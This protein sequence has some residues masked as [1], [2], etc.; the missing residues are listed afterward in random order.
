MV[1][2]CDPSDPRCFSKARSL[3]HSFFSQ[4]NGESQHTAHAMG[5]CH[6]D[7]GLFLFPAKMCLSESQKLREESWRVRFVAVVHSFVNEIK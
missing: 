3:A 5:H 2:L 6:I 1:N 4:R 7:S